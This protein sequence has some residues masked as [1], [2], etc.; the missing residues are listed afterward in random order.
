MM[1]SCMLPN[2]MDPTQPCTHKAS[3]GLVPHRACPTVQEW[4]ERERA[5][6]QEDQNDGAQTS[7]V[8][9]EWDE[10]QAEEEAGGVQGLHQQQLLYYI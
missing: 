1:E 9:G 6:D 5:W 2:I 4:D 8:Q 3:D 7:Q 10:G